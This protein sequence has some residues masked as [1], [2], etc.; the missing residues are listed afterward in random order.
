MV[1]YPQTYVVRAHA[2]PGIDTPWQTDGPAQTTLACAI[3]PEFDGPGGGFSPEELYALALG[4]CFVATFKVVAERSRMSFETLNVRA[5]LTVDR[6]AEGHPWMAAIDLH[7]LLRGAD[8][9]EK[10][11]R[12]LEK[13][14]ASCLILNSVKTEKRLHFD[15]A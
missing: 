15:L 13:T 2:Q 3:P 9:P 10:A 5:E 8:N 4:N 1:T 11:R 6:D 7:I 12:L 14:G